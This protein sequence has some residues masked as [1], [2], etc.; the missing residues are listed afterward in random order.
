MYIPQISD[1]Q[2][3]FVHLTINSLCFL[4][5]NQ[6]ADLLGSRY[7]SP[8]LTKTVSFDNI[9]EFHDVDNHSI[10]ISTI[11]EKETMDESQA[12]Q[13]LS[14]SHVGTNNG[15][16][17]VLPM[18]ISQDP[19]EV[20]PNSF[21]SRSSSPAMAQEPSSLPSLKVWDKTNEWK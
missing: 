9:T 3:K 8:V 11:Y 20:L 7:G 15:S 21:S 19:K 1:T 5:Q 4:Q 16:L 17:S 6:N 14:G 10:V 13:L 18:M 2:K 12:T